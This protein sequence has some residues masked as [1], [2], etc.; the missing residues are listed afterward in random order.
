VSDRAHVVDRRKHAWCWI[1]RSDLRIIQLDLPPQGR[2]TARSVYLAL[3]EL[4]SERY[5]TGPRFTTSQEEVAARADVSV[6][7]ARDRLAD[8]EH[9]GLLAREVDRRDGRGRRLPDIWYLTSPVQQPATIAGSEAPATI[10]GDL[11]GPSRARDGEEKNKQ[12]NGATPRTPQPPPAQVVEV[13]EAWRDAVGKTNAT[14]LDTK[15]RRAVE[16]ALKEFPFEDALD[17]GRGIALDPF[18]MG[19]NDRGTPF[20]DITIALRDAEH[21]EKFRDIYRGLRIPGLGASEWKNRK[22][23]SRDG[24]LADMEGILAL[25]SAE[26]LAENGLETIE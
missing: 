13:F 19:D 1:N 23:G 7:T 8:L 15:R 26:S 4:E 2:A 5:E 6:R 11:A 10:A 16:R 14:K 3:C 20:N 24:M 17:A 21:I 9:V 22:P 18:S 12:K 25:R